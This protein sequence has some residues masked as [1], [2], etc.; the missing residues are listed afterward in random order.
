MLSDLGLICFTGASIALAIPSGT[1]PSLRPEVRRAA[2]L[3]LG[4]AGRWGCREG[5]GRGCNDLRVP[6]A[7]CQVVSL[8][9]NGIR[10]LGS[11]IAWTYCQEG[12]CAHRGCSTGLLVP[13]PCPR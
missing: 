7:P 4:P 12:I 1:F 5:L 2:A 9:C 6:S 13:T 3:S 8:P 10:G 11:F